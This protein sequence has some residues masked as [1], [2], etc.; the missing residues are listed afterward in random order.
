[1]KRSASF[2]RRMTGAVLA[3]ILVCA[4]SPAAPAAETDTG[5]KNWTRTEKNGYVTVRLNVPDYEKLT[6]SQTQELAVRYSD[7]KTP[8]PLCSN[9][10]RGW[11]YVT[12]PAENATRPLEVYQGTPKEFADCV[13]VWQGHSYIDVPVGTDE[14]YLR[15]ILRGDASGNLNRNDALSRAEAFAF[16]TRLLSLGAPGQTDSVYHDVKPG[17]WYYDTAC[18]AQAAGIAAADTN[19]NPN[20]AVTRGEFTV[21]LAR[22]FRT[23]G[24]LPESPDAELPY[25]DGAAIPAW[26]AD[27]YRD[28]SVRRIDVSTIRYTGEEYD[29]NGD[30]PAEYLAE[31]GK[32]ITRDEVIEFLYSVLRFLPCYPTD[33]AIEWGFDTEMPV[34]D[35]STSTYPYTVALYSSLFCNPE[36]HPDRPAKHSKSFYSYDRLISGEADLLI[37]STKPTQATLDKAKAQG[38]TLELVPIAYD[39][40]VFFTNSAN[41][42]DN[43]TMKQI[44]EIYVN[45]PYNNWSALGGP[46]AVLVPYCRNMDSGSQAQMEE[47]FLQG[48]EIHP[49]IRRE[50]T[51]VTMASVLTDVEE[52]YRKEPLTYALGYSIYYYYQTASQILLSGDTLKLLKV[53]GVYPDDRTIADGTYPLSGYNYAVVRA[54]EPSGSPAREMIRFLLSPQGQEC[55][56]NAGFGPLTKTAE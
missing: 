15:G 38:V 46:N 34:I 36:G 16:I 37:I 45:D 47:F 39:A 42:T 31:A 13:T 11:F 2:L 17:D 23:L 30:L 33:E 43:L 53:N 21:M 20:R 29:A 54:D 6:W 35:G 12:V 4:L 3:A 28:L 10:Y 44:E 55:V 50:T 9:F 56:Q 48:R 26:A 19:F 27:A 18:A 51:S 7:D 24:W 22:A 14:L 1:M 41:P 32:P 5:A 49:D 40:M 25:A 52:A 8:V